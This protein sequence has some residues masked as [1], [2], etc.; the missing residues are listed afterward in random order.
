MR[1]VLGVI[2][3]EEAVCP[4]R[5][6]EADAGADLF[7]TEDKWIW[8]WSSAV[9]DTG[10]HIAIPKGYVGEIEPKSGLNV[11]H[12][13]VGWGTIDS[14]YTGSIRVKLYNLGW[15]PYKI[16]KWDKVAQLVIHPVL[17]CGFSQVETLDE[18]ERGDGGFGS[19]GK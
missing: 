12:N 17:L 2:L 5:A 8:P 4:D 16:H 9:F 6:H 18:T 3:D 15:K 19:T 11:K 10:V 14:G 7:S 13:L 1:E